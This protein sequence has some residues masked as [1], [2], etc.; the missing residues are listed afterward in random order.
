MVMATKSTFLTAFAQINSLI[1][2]MVAVASS[3]IARTAVGVAD[4]RCGRSR[5]GR[6]E[7]VVMKMVMMLIV[8]LRRRIFL[9][10]LTTGW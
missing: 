9:K 8:G 10:H 5:T 7:T 3:S 4:L 1:K 6:N 2:T